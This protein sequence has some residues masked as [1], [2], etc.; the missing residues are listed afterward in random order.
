MD[1]ASLLPPR[2]QTDLRLL[3]I[4]QAHLTTIAAIQARRELEVGEGLFLAEDATN[5]LTKPDANVARAE[6]RIED[7]LRA[8][9]G[10]RQRMRALLD[11]LHAVAAAAAQMEAANKLAE[12]R[13][14]DEARRFSIRRSAVHAGVYEAAIRTAADRLAAYW[15]RGLKPGELAQFAAWLANTAALVEVARKEK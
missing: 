13:L 8:T 3:A 1:P 2:Q 14:A 6:A 9:A 15:K 5:L 11:A 4:E 7:T 12:I 10:N